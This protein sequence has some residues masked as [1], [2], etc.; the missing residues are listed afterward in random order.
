MIDRT[1]LIHLFKTVKYIGF[2]VFLGSC[3]KAEVKNEGDF[4]DAVAPKML[5][6]CT[7]CHANG[8]AEKGFGY[9]DDVQRMIEKVKIAPGNP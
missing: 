4:S 2:L 6:V 1:V 9:V 3:N 7:Q 5:G 8:R